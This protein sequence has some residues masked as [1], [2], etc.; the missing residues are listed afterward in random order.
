MPLNSASKM[1]RHGRMLGWLWLLWVWIGVAAVEGA[2]L[3]PQRWTIKDLSGKPAAG[4][5]DNNLLT[6]VCLERDEFAGTPPGLLIDLGES[7]VLQRVFLAGRQCKPQFWSRGYENREKPPLGLIVAYVGDSSHTKNQVAEF[8]IPYDA[9]NP[10]E[11]E[12]DLRF[13]P[14][15]GRYLRIEVQTEI[16]WGKEHWPGYEVKVPAAAKHN[17]AWNISE[18]EIYGFSGPGALSRENAVVLPRG[19]ATPLLIAADDLCYYLGELTGKPHPVIVPEEAANY[20]G[21]LYHIVDLKAL[22]PTYEGLVK[23]R[24]AGRL[25]DGVNIER[26]GRE[27]FFKAWPHRAVLWSV[28]E[29]LDRQ[30]VRWL[31]PSAHGEHVPA[32]Q[33]VKLDLLPL[34]YTPSASRIYANFGVA[35]Y[36][37]WP[38]WMKQSIP[39]GFLCFWRNHWNESWGGGQLVFG[40]NE[41]PKPVSTYRLKDDYR[42]RFDGYPHNFDAVVPARILQSHPEWWGYAKKERKRLAPGTPGAVTMC[43]SNPELIQWVAGKMLEVHKAAPQP[44]YNLLPMDGCRF[45]ECERCAKVNGPEEPN[46]VPWVRI[47]NVSLS[48]P[49]YAFICAVARAVKERGGSDIMVGGLAYADVFKPPSNIPAFPENVQM[50]VCMYGS[51]NLPMNSPQNETFKQAWDTWHQKCK[52]LTYYDYAL[53]QESGEDMK[54]PV[55]LVAAIV[56]R[57]RYLRSAGGLNGG[58]QATLE[59]LPYNP[60]NFYAYPRTRWNAD[61]T[62]DQLLQE[63]FSGYYRE[64]SVPM[65]AY[66]KALENYHQEQNVNLHSGGYCYG[67]TP[68]AFPLHV[69]AAVKKHLE[70]AEQKA[71]HWVV[72]QRVATVREAFDWLIAARGL[73]GMDLSDVT[74]YPKVE[75]GAKPLSLD[76]RK[77]RKVNYAELTKNGEWVFWAQG[78]LESTLYFAKQGKC[79]ITIVARGVPWQDEWPVIHAF[80]GTKHA[81]AATVS[82]K[83]Y[84]EYSFDAEAPAG[85][86]DILLNYW[87]AAEGGRR[88]IL[89]K[90]IRVLQE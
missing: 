84:T 4:L 89:I 68:G 28:W 82:A 1:S 71:K 51:P 49:Y 13:H 90:G 62:A 59:N 42:E 21:T 7:C 25:P 11:T 24:E 70:E 83:E 80:L 18:L 52:R 88:N 75:S 79:R 34:R 12:V 15:A 38:C 66:Y 20:P 27:V 69:L 19:S 43:L 16:N 57:A 64:A 9:G 48:N 41:I 29:F 58:S 86:W 40:G 73:Q 5:T 22:A 67:I 81:G 85:V 53:L 10:V 2:Q 35:D 44:V 61:L 87:N 39:Q 77:M 56:D 60:W 33:G 37:P 78:K 14:A 31:Y 47:R 30:G 36:L 8:T 3:D 26:E 55:P 65:L 23:N 32:G 54:L 72:L 76:L 63:F 17:L 74:A 50:E 45:C 46:G 6:H